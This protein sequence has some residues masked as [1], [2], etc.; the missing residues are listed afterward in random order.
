MPSAEQERLFAA[1]L[2]S[3]EMVRR[4]ARDQ[5]L[6]SF[7]PV[8]PANFPAFTAATAAADAAFRASVTAAAADAGIV[9]PPPG[10]P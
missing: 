10:S 9:I 4:V 5:A 3:A 1:A 8:D 7:S 6:A 2:K